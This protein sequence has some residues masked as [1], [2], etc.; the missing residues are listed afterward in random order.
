MVIPTTRVS[1]KGVARAS[2]WPHEPHMTLLKERAR[3]V[4]GAKARIITI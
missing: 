4:G 1:T 2:A 3:A